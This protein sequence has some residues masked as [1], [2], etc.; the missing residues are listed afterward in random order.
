MAL[1]SVRS[2]RRL[3]ER[4]DTDLLFRR[5]LDTGPA[6]PAFDPTTVTR[7]RPRPDA[8]GLAAAFFD[9]VLKEALE[10]GLCSG[11]HFAWTGR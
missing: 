11:D 8:H 2:E 3:A 7:N 6:E 5:F 4:V 10:A 1:Y 9:A